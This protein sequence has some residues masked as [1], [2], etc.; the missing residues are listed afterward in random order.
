MSAQP[1]SFVGATR[2]VAGREITSR[3]RDKGFLISTGITLAILLAVLVISK[4]TSGGTTTYHVGLEPGAGVSAQSLQTQG[5]AV[6]VQV[7]VRSGGTDALL[8]KGKLDAV[9]G[10]SGVRVH[11]EL[12]DRLRAVIDAT[13][14]QAVA[15]QRLQQQ[16]IDPAKVQQAFAVTPLRVT[17]LDP[18]DKRSDRRKEVAFVGTLLLYGQLLTYGIWVAFGVAEEKSSRVVEVL[19]S[20]VP[21]RA[22]LA[23]KIVGIGLLG[24]GQLLLLTVVS[25]GV[26]A[27]LGVVSI[28]SD[29]LLPTGIVLAWFLLGFAFYAT[30]YAAAAAR[31]SRQED[32]QNVTSP[33]TFALVGSFFAAVY[34]SNNSDA[35]LAKV[36]AVVPPFSALVN[37]PLVAGGGATAWMVALAV[38]LMLGAIAGLVVVGARLYEGAVLH[39]GSVLSWRSAWRSSRTRT[40]PS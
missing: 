22:L 8:R 26:A 25:L 3:A 19:L 7:R 15:T 17:A 11:K 30:A 33:M 20:A 29:V 14:Q 24:L 13:Q 9:V 4:L 12:P 16:G 21:P 28:D 10:A 37:P 27:A 39:T 31:V 2:L 38:V 6:G 23:G 36:L 35:T 40:T 18:P 1:V 5:K 32:V 34:A